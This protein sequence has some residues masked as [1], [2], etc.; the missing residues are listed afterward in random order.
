MVMFIDNDKGLLLY[1]MGHPCDFHKLMDNVI[2]AQENS[3]GIFAITTDRDLY[4]MSYTNPFSYSE[5]VKIM[6]DVSYI[7]CTE[8][9]TVILKING[10]VVEYNSE[11]CHIMSD[12]VQ[13]VCSHFHYIMLNENG[14]IWLN[15][16]DGSLSKIASDAKYIFQ[17]VGEYIFYTDY[18]D[19]LWGRGDNSYGQFGL[20]HTNQISGFAKISRDIVQIRCGYG[21]LVL[22]NENGD[23]WKY[24]NGCSERIATN[25]L[26]I[27]I[28]EQHNI[29]M[30]D[31]DGT[32]YIKN[33]PFL[34]NI[35]QI[36]CCGCFS[37]Y[38]YFLKND[39]SVWQ[40][41]VDFQSYFGE[42]ASNILAIDASQPFANS[43]KSC[44]T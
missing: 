24:G 26:Q 29:I 5:P 27:T 28:S 31:N 21:F 20:G 15:A 23:V 18:N 3:T 2:C 40:Y 34:N 41:S 4:F 30:L 12:I 32:V 33:K 22:L 35:A 43:Y 19:D 39:C 11:F 42:I 14:E 16:G 1:R 13:I 9:E 7:D 10:D 38:C 8:E 17:D 25:I 36:M 44:R 37:Y 6:C